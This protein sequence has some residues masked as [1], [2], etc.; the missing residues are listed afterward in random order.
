[1]PGKVESRST[2]ETGWC[3]T[4]SRPTSPLGA[5]MLAMPWRASV[6]A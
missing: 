6:P 1:M 4:A 5:S 2:R 3:S